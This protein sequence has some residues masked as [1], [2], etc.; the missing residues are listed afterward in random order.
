MTDVKKSRRRPRSDG[1]RNREQLLDVAKTAFTMGE[2]DIPLD[3]VARRAGVGIGTLYRHFPNRDALIEAVYRAELDR[4]AE[5]APVLAAQHPPV[6][7]LRAWMRLFVDYIAAKQVI[8]PALNGLVG[9]TGA[10]YAHSGDVLKAAVNSLVSA[11]IAAGEFRAD[12]EPLDLLR[13][14]A[15]VSNFSA[16]PGWESSAKRLVDI[17]I[18]GSRSLAS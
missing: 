6:E 3:E 4:L 18:A 8:A 2:V 14:L 9:G 17:L 1:Q 15:G 12:I 10:L 13:A 16:G 7:A 11:A 5:A